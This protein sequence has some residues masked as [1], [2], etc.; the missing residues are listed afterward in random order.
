MSKPPRRFPRL[1]ILLA[2]VLALPC[3]ATEPVQGV[4]TDWVLQAVARPSPSST[5]FVELRDSPMLRQPLRLQGEYQHHVDGSLVRRVES[6]YRETTTLTAGEVVIEREGRAP[7]R[8]ALRQVPELAAIQ[9]GFGALLSGDRELLQQ[10]YEV[11]AQGVREHWALRLV[12]RESR[13]AA[14][15]AWIELHGR[16]SELRCVESHPA[17]GDPLY[18]LMAGAAVAA[19]GEDDPSALAA[20]C[21]ADAR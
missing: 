17:K 2:C 16:G 18:T 5:P 8:V 14:A 1:A 4:D 11:Q 20:L 7:R 21:R 13:L 12:P 15:L 10:T 6:P 19:A 9:A 3:V